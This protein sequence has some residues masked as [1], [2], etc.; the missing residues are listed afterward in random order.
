MSDEKENVK[1]AK[2]QGELSEQELKKV[3]GGEVTHS[4][5]NITKQ[6]DASSPK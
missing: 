3:A 6:L 5:L 2:E 1:P 4:D